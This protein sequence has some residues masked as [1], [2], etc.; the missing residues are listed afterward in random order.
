MNGQKHL[1]RKNN[2]K[3]FYIKIT[4]YAPY[5]ITIDYYEKAGSFGTAIN[6]AT[7]KYFK[8]YK[9]NGKK[10]RIKNLSIQAGRRILSNIK[11]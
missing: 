9:K 6:R 11:L 5:P 10:M 3:I 7:K 1:R 8:D 2:M 4:G